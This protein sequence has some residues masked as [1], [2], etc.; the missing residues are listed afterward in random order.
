MK[1]IF[2]LLVLS[3]TLLLSQNEFLVNTLTDTTQRWPSVDKDGSGNYYV[4]WQSIFLPSSISP[5][6]IYLQMFNSNDVKVGGE[7]LVN[8]ATGKKQEKP[9]IATNAAGRSV[10]A[11]SSYTDFTSIYDIKARIFNQNFPQ[12]NEILVN[13]NTLNSQ[14]NPA[15]AIRLNGEFVVAWDSW[16]QDGGDRGVYAQRFDL[17]G[18]KVGS[19]FSVNT[20]LAYSQAKPRVKYFSDGKFIIIWESFKQDGSGYG[21]YGR[22]FN[23]DGTANT[24]EFPINTYTTDY[25]WFGDVEVFNDDS[26]I[27]AWCSWEQD[28]DDGGIYVQRFNASGLKVG[29]EVR[30]NK[31]TSQYQWLPRVKKLTGKNVAVVWSSWK[32]D[33]SREGIVAAF[34]DENN[35]RYTFE[36]VV[37]NYSESF[38]WEPD[39]IVTDENEILVVW[40]SWEQFGNDYD[41]VARRIGLEKPQGVINPSFNSH[42]TGTTTAKIVTHVVDSTA[43]TGHT[44]LVSF[45]VPGSSDT[46]YAKIEDQNTSQTKIQNFPINKGVHTFYLTSTFDGVAVEFLPQFKLELDMNPYFINNSS[47]NLFF[48][49]VLPASGQKLLAPIDVALIWGS[50]DTLPTGQC[51]AP[52]DTALSTTGAKNVIIPFLAINMNNNSRLTILVKELAATKNFKWNPKEE[53]VFITPPPYQVN[54]FNTHAQINS[55]TSAGNIIWPN[56]GDTNFV[57]TKRPITPADTFYFTTNRAYVISDIVNENILPEKFELFQNYPNPFNPITTIGYAI[58]LLRGDERGV[59]TTLK[60]YDI[61]GKEIAVLVNEELRPGN[62]NVSFNTQKY[63]MASGVSAKGRYASG[64]YFYRLQAEQYSKTKKMILLR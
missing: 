22:I 5:Y 27:V 49:Y 30:I 25:Q 46:V 15:V 6:P 56:I 47:S 44:Y 14:S 2:L 24:N 12:G 31:T 26:F 38:Q 35:Q 42:L 16:Y 48:S 1:K 9:V 21:M 23:S 61:L 10:I 43:L 55:N 60:I 53:I 41:I 34:I 51:A 52:L 40:S 62:Y 13:T 58:P 18:N 32:Q 45:Q 64:V 33:G 37:N 17:T 19:E 57:L 39:F 3:S 63:Q 59:L 11:W 36:T 7:I 50:T 20:T 4:V 8:E 28:G 54:P 29:S